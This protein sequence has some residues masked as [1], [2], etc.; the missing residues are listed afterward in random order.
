VTDEEAGPESKAGEQRA[1]TIQDQVVS[2]LIVI[3]IDLDIVPAGLVIHRV[4]FLRRSR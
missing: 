1:D 2:A 3:V 4:F